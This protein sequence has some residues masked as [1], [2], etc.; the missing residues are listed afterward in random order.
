[1]YAHS[2]ITALDS[3]RGIAAFLVVMNHCYLT[4]W[5]AGPTL[6]GVLIGGRASVIVFFV[7]S[8]Y[9]LARSLTHN[10]EPA[11]VFIARRFFRIGYH[12][13]PPSWPPRSSAPS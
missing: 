2:R 5:P 7:L 11:S 8:G 12:L 1:M 13:P 3:V 9:V 6:A 4:F 10:A